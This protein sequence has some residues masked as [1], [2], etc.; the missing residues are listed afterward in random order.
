MKVIIYMHCGIKL[1]GFHHGTVDFFKVSP[2][3]NPEH[4]RSN[5]L[6]HNNSTT[7]HLNDT[8]PTYDK[9]QKTIE[10]AGIQC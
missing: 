5:P 7:A 4:S 6:E 8:H 9:N 1:D 10:Y 3:L 2:L